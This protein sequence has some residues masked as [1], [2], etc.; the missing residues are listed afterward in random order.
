VIPKQE[1]ARM[2]EYDDAT[3]AHC[4]II[5]KKLMSHMKQ[6]LPDTAFV[7]LAVE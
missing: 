2:D 1:L 4:M 3:V 6:V 7:Y 5:A